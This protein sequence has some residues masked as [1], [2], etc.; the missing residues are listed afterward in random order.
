M[1][2]TTQNSNTLQREG[3]GGINGISIASFLQ[4]LE[5]EHH[6]CRVHVQSGDETGTLYFTDGELTDA[7]QG[8]LH[9]LEA[10]YTIVSWEDPSIALDKS[11]SRPKEIKHPLGYILLNAAKQQDEQA[12]ITT[13]PTI[14]YVSSET[15]E[16]SDYQNTIE[17]LSGIRG[18][19]SFYLLN[20]AGK[21]VA[22]SAPDQ[23]LEELVI[24]CVI[25]S[26][27]LK[28]TLGTKSPRRIHMQLKDGGS[29]LI[30]PKS[31][32][33]LGMILDPHSSATEITNQI[34][35]GLSVTLNP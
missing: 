21:T 2:D 14:T 33:I 34:N 32:K 3:V 25:T 20:G 4:M 10:A 35:S 17:I 8:P 1:T 15:E 28:N 22:H 24:Y 29:L 12:E 19:R 6:S 23:T 9:G 16:N 27:N 5:Q 31:G 11:V 26:S 30:M 18:I 7:T 13:K